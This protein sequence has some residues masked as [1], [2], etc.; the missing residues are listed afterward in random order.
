MGSSPIISKNFHPQMDMKGDITHFYPL[1][2]P[3]C[4]HRGH[5]AADSPQDLVRSEARF[6]AL[7]ARLASHAEASQGNIPCAQ[8]LPQPQQPAVVEAELELMRM[9]MIEMRMEA[10]KY[11]NDVRRLQEKHKVLV[12]SIVQSICPGFEPWGRVLRW[13]GMRAMLA[14]L[15]HI[16]IR[17]C[18]LFGRWLKENEECA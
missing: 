16:A 18:N 5:R 6:A 17:K 15:Q 9:G 11:A 14:R 1:L 3:P 4:W 7:E 13:D 8:P 10:E 2:G 12:R